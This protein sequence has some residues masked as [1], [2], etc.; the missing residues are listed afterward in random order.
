[1]D[2]A[3]AADQ[4]DY[5]R[6]YDSA[7]SELL[8]A[9]WG[10]NLHM[11]LFDRPDDSLASAQLRMKDHMARHAHLKPGQ[12]IF[13]AACGVGATAIHLARNYGVC[14]K[15]TNIAQAQL[16][17]G[18]ERVHRAGLADRVSFA[19]ADYHDLGGGDANFDC[20][21]CQEALLYAT[22]RRQVFAEA[23]R[24]V[25]PGGRIVFTDLTLSHKLEPEARTSFM[26]EI[27]APHLWA[28][29]DYERLLSDMRFTTAERQDLNPHVALTFAAVASNLANVRSDFAERLG[30]ETVR[31]TEFRIDRQLEMARAGHLGCCFF[32]VGV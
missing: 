12:A 32:V 30:E 23:R 1:M 14:V 5:R 4:D 27:R 18:A 28:I 13:E 31:G 22:D 20:W 17:E 2:A 9:I 29:E 21:W 11:G 15:A 6:F 7:L 24:V 19:F 3:I 25:K 16:D 26:S 8:S 10:G